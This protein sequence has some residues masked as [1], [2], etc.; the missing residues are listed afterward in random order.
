M[1]WLCWV[2][3]GLVRS[4]CRF[5]LDAAIRPPQTDGKTQIAVD[6]RISSPIKVVGALHI[7]K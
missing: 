3:Q 6:G 2:D 4:R 5:N 1:C 7:P